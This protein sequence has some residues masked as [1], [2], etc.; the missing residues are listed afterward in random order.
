MEANVLGVRVRFHALSQAF[1]G[2]MSLRVPSQCLSVFLVPQC[3]LG[4]LSVV[5]LLSPE[6]S[7]AAVCN[8]F[9][10]QGDWSERTGEE[11]AMTFV[12]DSAPACPGST[13]KCM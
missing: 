5:R 13:K 4:T 12:F 7:T 11:K 8:Q 3:S 1:E 2:D 6:V 9:V 10:S